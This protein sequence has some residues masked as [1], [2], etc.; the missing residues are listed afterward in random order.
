[1]VDSSRTVGEVDIDSGK[2]AAEVG[3]CDAEGGLDHRVAAGRENGSHFGKGDVG[4]NV[5]EAE[6]FKVE[7]SVGDIEGVVSR[8]RTS[9]H[10]EL[11]YLIR[12][13]S[14]V[15]WTAADDD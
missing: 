5:I 2:V 10:H 14:Y 8:S 9:W 12:D 11:N 15:C 3:S 7:L 13:E 1:M 4:S 6:M